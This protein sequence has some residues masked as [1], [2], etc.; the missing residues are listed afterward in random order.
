MMELLSTNPSAHCCPA[1][2]E[3]LSSEKLRSL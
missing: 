3:Q 1:V 2:N